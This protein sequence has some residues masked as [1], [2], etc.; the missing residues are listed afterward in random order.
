MKRVLK[1]LIL[2]TGIVS[3]S[4]ILISTPAHT[5][6]FRIAPIKVVFSGNVRSAI[7]TIINDDKKRFK[8]EAKLVEW[9][10]DEE[11][12]DLYTPSKDIIYY[13]K[14]ITVEPE[15][16]RAIRLG[17]KMPP[18]GVERTYRIFIQGVPEDI[19]KKATAV[20]I[21]LRFGVPVFVKPVREKVAGDIEKMEL[22]DG[23]L[24]ITIKN[25]GNVHFRINTIGVTGLDEKGEK[26]FEESIA[27]WYLLHGV[28]RVYRVKLKKDVCERLKEIGVAVDTDRVDFSGRL[29][30]QK[31][32][33]V[34]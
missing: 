24:L 3:L 21:A 9:K 14:V 22:N 5:K 10:Q 7:V 6:G 1:R 11:G 15:K 13:P 28:K 19:K 31:A 2:Y 17:V 18:A 23:A 20:H 25:S 34:P 29:D 8:F 30:V 4:S 33:C 32:M 16:R 27:G 12:K 26:V